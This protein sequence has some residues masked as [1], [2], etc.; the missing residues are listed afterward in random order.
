MDEKKIFVKIN[1]KMV[2]CSNGTDDCRSFKI[3]GAGIPFSG[4]RYV[5]KT[6]GTAAKRA[7]SKLYSKVN[8]DSNFA[9]FQNKNSI[10]FILQET[11][12]GAGKKTKAFE[13][14]RTKLNKPVVV[15]IKGQEIV[16]KYKYDVR[17]LKASVDDVMKE[18]M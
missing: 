9:K 4:G 8:N 6:A 2:K 16:Y 10:K 7:G 12:K 18:M 13:V 15:K 3:V 14:F 5:A 17:Q 1:K 11:T